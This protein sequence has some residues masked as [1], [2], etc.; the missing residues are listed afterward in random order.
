MEDESAFWKS[1][2]RSGGGG[3]RKLVHFLSLLFGY[4]KSEKDKLTSVS[5]GYLLC[6]L[7]CVPTFRGCHEDYIRQ[8]ASMPSSGLGV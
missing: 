7:E 8:Q 1:C 4:G 5:R 6:D 2:K 3:G